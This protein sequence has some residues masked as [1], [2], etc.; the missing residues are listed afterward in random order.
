[1]SEASSRSLCCSGHAAVRR[2]SRY[3]PVQ[4]AALTSVC[5][6]LAEQP[7]PVRS[8]LFRLVPTVSPEQTRTRFRGKRRKPPQQQNRFHG[9]TGRCLPLGVGAYTGGL[10]GAVSAAGHRSGGEMDEIG[11]SIIKNIFV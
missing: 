11:S 2:L 6:R 10:N 8:D 9:V 3:I 7:A 4:P 1:M 5:F